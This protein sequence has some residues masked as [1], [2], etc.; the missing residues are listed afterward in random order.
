[1]TALRFLDDA[2]HAAR[3]ERAMA[4]L[5]LPEK[6]TGR[7]EEPLTELAL[8]KISEVPDAFCRELLLRRGLGGETWPVLSRLMNYSERQLHR[9][10][11]TAL[12]ALETVLQ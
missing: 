10:Y 6:E 4:S 7:G 8:R 11:K 5:A 12:Q 2:R 9:K 3:L 1:M